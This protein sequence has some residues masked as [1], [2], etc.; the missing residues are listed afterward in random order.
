MIVDAIILLV[1]VSLLLCGL[2]LLWHASA[3]AFREWRE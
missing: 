1:G 2:W 3:E